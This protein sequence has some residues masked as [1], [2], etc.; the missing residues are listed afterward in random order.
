MS[1]IN[2]TLNFSEK[3]KGPSQQWHVGPI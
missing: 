1:V 2:K 3:S